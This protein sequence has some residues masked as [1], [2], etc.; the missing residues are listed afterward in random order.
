[1]TI[2]DQLLASRYH[3][4]KN[5]GSGAFG[6]TFLAEDQNI[7]TQPKCVVK[8]LK[9]SVNDPNH[10]EQAKKLFEKEAAALSKVGTHNQIPYLKDYFEAEGNFYLVQDFIDGTPLNQELAA[11]QQWSE[12]AVLALL[13]DCLPILDFIHSQNPLIIHRDIKPAN[14]I[15]RR[16]DGKIVLVDFGAVKE[17]FQTR[18]VQSTIAIGT[19]GY[20]PA[21]QIR[22][23]PRPASDIFALGMV[24]IQ[25]LTGVNPIDLPEDDNGEL[26]WQYTEDE[27]GQLQ[28]RVTVSAD[29]AD[30]LSKMIRHDF[31][32]RYQSAQEVIAALDNQS[33]NRQQEETSVSLPEAFASTI[34]SPPNPE[35]TRSSPIKEDR[36]QQKATPETEHE[37]VEPVTQN[38]L[39][40]TESTEV[41]TAP[42]QESSLSSPGHGSRNRIVAW[43]Q[44][45]SA[46]KIGIASVI[47]IVATFGM[48]GLNTYQAKKEDETT[49]QQITNFKKEITALFEQKKYQDC[50][51]VVKANSSSDQK[52]Q[53][54]RDEFHGKC[55]LVHAESLANNDQYLEALQ[56]AEEVNSKSELHQEAQTKIKVWSNKLLNQGISH[57]QTNG[58]LDKLNEVIFIM[59]NDNPLREQTLQKKEELNNLH[60]SNEALLA[61]AQTAVDNQDWDQAKQKAEELQKVGN[62]YPYW[63]EQAEVIVDQVNEAQEAVVSTPTPSQ[64]TT[65]KTTTPKPTPTSTPKEEKKEVVDLCQDE[66]AVDAGFC[67]Q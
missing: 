54:I 59:S 50:I 16:E 53:E 4:L 44:S 25:A 20:M 58:T 67:P 17:S 8:Q 9:P 61:S 24:A 5:I 31:Q 43:L 38:Q 11:G 33:P 57:Y 47:L 22:G 51:E 39:P 55:A 32:H 52:I 45:S 6:V 37:T 46:K 49:Q 19:R 1:M 35:I 62:G 56:L 40:L 28:P 60:K 15:R 29:L 42:S 63:Q 2:E 64:P 41:S 34:L 7:P 23:K 12:A 48:A 65:S 18:L 10:F 3:I 30:V 14:L 26:V 66:F 36:N 27:E 21:E 13:K